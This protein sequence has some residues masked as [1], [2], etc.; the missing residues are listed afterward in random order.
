MLLSSSG[1]FKGCPHSWLGAVS[2]LMNEPLTILIAFHRTY[3]LKTIH[4][5]HIDSFRIS[6]IC[7]MKYVWTEHIPWKS[8]ITI[9]FVKKYLRTWT[10]FIE[11]G[12]GDTVW[13]WHL[14]LYFL[15]ALQISLSL[16]HTWDHSPGN[17]QTLERDD[18]EFF[19]YWKIALYR[20][21]V[22]DP[23]YISDH[24]QNQ[25]ESNEAWWNLF[26]YKVCCVWH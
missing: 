14:L 8:A 13:C 2:F 15:A 16:P 11:G 24:V 6:F 26:E 20:T 25:W 9:K 3:N 1:K 22:L 10:V 23:I 21:Q 17:A 7:C 5:S 18:Q 12:R 19:K 4:F